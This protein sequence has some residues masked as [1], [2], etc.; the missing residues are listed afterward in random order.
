MAQKCFSQGPTIQ[1]AWILASVPQPLGDSQSVRARRLSDYVRIRI[2]AASRDSQ[3]DCSTLHKTT[4]LVSFRVFELQWWSVSSF[5]LAH[6]K[7]SAKLYI[8]LHAA[9]TQPETLLNFLLK[10]HKVHKLR[11]LQ[12]S[13]IPSPLS[14]LLWSLVQ[15][16]NC[17]R[18]FSPFGRLHLVW[19]HHQK[20]VYQRTQKYICFYQENKI[21]VSKTVNHSL[22]CGCCFLCSPTS[23][24]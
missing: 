21:H 9:D 12:P 24:K 4:M 1:N 16:R 3:T 10:N 7:P 19:N 5:E 23:T 2:Y 8:A 14:A 13:S 15:Q 11:K 20:Q 6:L 17:T 18:V 22:V